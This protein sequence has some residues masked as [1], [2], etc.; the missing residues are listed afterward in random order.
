MFE[1]CRATYNF[2]HKKWDLFQGG[3]GLIA[4]MGAC[5]D[6]LHP[7][8]NRSTALQCIQH[9]SNSISCTLYDGVAADDMKLLL[10]ESAKLCVTW[11]QHCTTTTAHLNLHCASSLAVFMLYHG[12]F[13]VA[14][15]H[16]LRLCAFDCQNHI[17]VCWMSI[18]CHFWS[19]TLSDTP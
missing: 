11:L 9:V 16:T 18:I 13:D 10:M 15:M 5:C 3:D 12:S 6:Y 2:W 4:V 14:C 7:R 17:V 19:L 8:L 1:T